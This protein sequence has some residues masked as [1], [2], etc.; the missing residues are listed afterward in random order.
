[1]DGHPHSV[2]H[3]EAEKRA[4][5]SEANWKDTSLTTRDQITVTPFS[6]LFASI[7]LTS[8]IANDSHFLHTNSVFIVNIQK[9]L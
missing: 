2:L 9:F 3:R 5:M 4:E 1:M 8:D 6:L 7:Q